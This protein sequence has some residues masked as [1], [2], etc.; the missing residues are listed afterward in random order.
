[1][2]ITE[3][4]SPRSATIIDQIDQFDGPDGKYIEF[5]V[6]SGG[7]IINVRKG[8]DTITYYWEYDEGYNRGC[9]DVEVHSGGRDSYSLVNGSSFEG[10]PQKDIERLRDQ[11]RDA[12][13]S[14]DRYTVIEIRP[15]EWCKA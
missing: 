2:I 9:A 15:H 11:I 7:C 3:G 5:R 13:N 10:N 14:P 4:R 12:I 6:G 1:M 8:F